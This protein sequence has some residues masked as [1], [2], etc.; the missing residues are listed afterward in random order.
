MMIL[1]AVSVAQKV[2]YESN[3]IIVK[4]HPNTAKSFFESEKMTG[5]RA[6][7]GDFD[8]KLEFPD[9]VRPEKEFNVKSHG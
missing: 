7:F 6:T 2:D 5:F 9:A 3:T 8:Y 1:C 4:L